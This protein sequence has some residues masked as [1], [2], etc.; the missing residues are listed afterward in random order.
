MSKKPHR[1][2]P[3]SRHPLFP[4][5]VALWA[6]ALLG[7]ASLAV[8]GSLGATARSALLLVVAA[9]GAIGASFAARRIAKPKAEVAAQPG[10]D[11]S[12]GDALWS[13][14]KSRRRAL[15]DT[16][17]LPPLPQETLAAP[18]D[19]EPEILDVSN[20]ELPPTFDSPPPA[21]AQ[22]ES[23]ATE[24]KAAQRIAAA[25]LSELS[26]LELLERLALSM[27]RRGRDRSAAPVSSAD[28]AALLER[29]YEAL[30]NLGLATAAAPRAEARS[31][32]EP[33]VV[34]PATAERQPARHLP[35]ADASEL[36]SPARLDATPDDR[37]PGHAEK[38]LRDALA[39]LQRMSGAA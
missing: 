27:Q 35:M 39:A 37:A 16:D 31:G 36:S 2:Q 6:G 7:L 24:G 1:R 3:I 29:G 30:R 22:T 14:L 26:Q 13:E 33:M 38:A 25:E 34:F 21:P 20:V 10:D 9:A 8:T 17:E 23:A 18:L 19:R 4:A 11:E 5:I 28:K 15:A 32:D 12:G